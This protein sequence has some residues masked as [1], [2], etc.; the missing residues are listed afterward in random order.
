MQFHAGNRMRKEVQDNSSCDTQ[1][2][3][4]HKNVSEF[5]EAVTFGHQDQFVN[6]SRFQDFPNLLLTEN[7][8]QFQTPVSVLFD[9]SSEIMRSLARSHNGYMPIVECT[10]LGNSE[11]NESVRNKE[12]IVDDQREQ[13]DQS[14]R[15]ILIQKEQHGKHDQ[16]GKDRKST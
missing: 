1:L 10:M 2:F 6:A 5:V 7:S 3:A 13:D 14:I 16:P 8:N 12:K 4:Q 9:C 15:L 11:K